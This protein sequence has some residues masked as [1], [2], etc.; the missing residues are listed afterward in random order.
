MHR[1]VKH[2][3]MVIMATRNCPKVTVVSTEEELHKA[4]RKNDSEINAVPHIHS[5]MKARDRSSSRSADE[6]GRTMAAVIRDRE[7]ATTSSSWNNTNHEAQY[8][9][10]MR[11]M[12]RKE[13]KR[14]FL[15][16]SAT[17]PKETFAMRRKENTSTQGIITPRVSMLLREG[18]SQA[19]VTL[20][21]VVEAAVVG[22]GTLQRV[23]VTDITEI[24]RYTH[25]SQAA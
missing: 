16:S 17:R 12:R 8:A 4:A 7:Q 2:E 23:P 13:V 15:R 10:S 22:K 11:P 9:E 3:M 25:N 20:G 1:G 14:C 5:M 24:D 21:V 19:V 18:R 6:L